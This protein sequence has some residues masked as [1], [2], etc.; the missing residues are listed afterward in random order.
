MRVW[1]V[2]TPRARRTSPTTR[3]AR[4]RLRQ[5]GAEIRHPA[6][7]PRQPA[8]PG[9]VGGPGS[10][11][12]SFQRRLGCYKV[13]RLIPEER[14]EPGVP[15]DPKDETSSAS[16]GEPVVP[17]SVKADAP[18]D[19]SV[20]TEPKAEVEDTEAPADAASPAA[21]LKRVSA[22]GRGRRGRPHR[23]DRGGEARAASREGARSRRRSRASRPRRR[24]GS[25]GFGTRR[26][27]SAPSRWP[28]TQS[29]CLD[30][31][32]DFSK[33]AKE[34]QKLVAG[35]SIAAVLAVGGS[36]GWVA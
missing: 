22:I 18:V 15:D 3:H 9:R 20:D 27:R 36:L 5:T 14:L 13:R 12:P 35:A 33:W 29:R 2:G 34:N 17:P 8:R 30:R 10:R 23:A 31:A 21:I 16:A 26:P 1:R 24:S 6:R 25:R 28:R 7:P 19:A 11:P 32:T 4:P